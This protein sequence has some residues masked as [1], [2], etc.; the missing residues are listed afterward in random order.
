MFRATG[1]VALLVVTGLCGNLAAQATNKTEK[2]EDDSRAITNS[3]GMKLVLIPAGEFVMGSPESEKDRFKSE[4]PQHRVRI[5]RPFY[6]GQYPVTLGEFLKFY[7]DADYKLEIER[8]RKGDFGFMSDA[9]KTSDKRPWAPGF[10]NGDDHPAVFV[11]WNDAAAFCQWLSKKEGR[12]Y[13]LPTEAQWE[14][15]CRAGSTTAFCFGD[16][17]KDLDDYGWYDGNGGHGTK[18]VGKKKPNAWGVYEMHGC[19]W[20]W[21]ADWYDENYYANSPTDD[22]QG[23]SEGSMRAFRGGGWVHEAKNC[24]SARRAYNVPGY[25]FYG[26]G[27]RVARV[28]AD[29]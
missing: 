28:A 26:L 24:R 29:M 21:C 10:E 1:A 12:Q 11:S 27:F 16:D 7:H 20:Q 22:P 23:P 8:D 2:K 19:V 15:A 25:R 17:E 13:R 14:Y 9:G 5:T 4:G 3:I 18:A 6:L